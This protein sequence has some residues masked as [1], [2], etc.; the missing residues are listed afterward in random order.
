[1]QTVPP[2]LQAIKLNH[3][4]AG[5]AIDALNVRRN[6]TTFVAVPEWRRGVSVLPEDSVAAYSL[7]DTRGHT[8]T[9]QAQFSCPHPGRGTF[10][11]RAVDAAVDPPPP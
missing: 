4:P 9:I 11:V 3:D 7:T 1:V 5:A 10:E 8:L 6:K 2:R